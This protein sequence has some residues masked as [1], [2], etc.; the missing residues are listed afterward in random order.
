MRQEDA[1][2][3]TILRSGG[4]LY[5]E[6]DG[7]IASPPGT[8]SEPSALPL[9]E[10]GGD[11][12]F[13]S[14]GWRKRAPVAVAELLNL[15]GD[16]PAA[17]EA[18]EALARLPEIR[19]VSLAG[20]AF[21]DESLRGLDRLPRL[22]GLRLEETRATSA[23]LSTIGAPE[24]IEGLVLIGEGRG[25]VVSGVRA[26]R[27][28]RELDVVNVLIGP[29]DAAALGSLP[30]LEELRLSEI[31]VTEAEPLKSLAG[32][33]SLRSLEVSLLD[34]STPGAAALQAIADLPRLERLRI[35]LR[36]EDLPLFANSVNLRYLEPYASISESAGR[37]LSRARPDCVLRVRGRPSLYLLDGEPTSRPAS[38][39]A[40]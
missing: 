29:E 17:D 26:L 19:I 40:R 15:E 10:R 3:E 27:N 32:A 8:L 28:L 24:R 23:G 9:F 36:D 37:S 2:I 11:M 7:G 1:A 22:Q 13:R 31:R 5:T 14:I 38:E 21:D 16:D 39:R 34:G 35:A 18:I 20:P 25:D 33:P 4:S 30:R 6:T 12:L